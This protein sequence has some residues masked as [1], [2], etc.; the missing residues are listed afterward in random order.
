M[1]P[2]SLFSSFNPRIPA[3]CDSIHAVT[4]NPSIEFQST[5]PC[6][7][8][9]GCVVYGQPGLGVS[10]HA[11]LRDATQQEAAQSRSQSRFNP[12]IPAG[13]DYPPTWKTV[14]QSS[15]NPRIPAGCDYL[16]R[17]APGG[18]QGFNPRIPAGCDSPYV[19]VSSGKD[20]FQSTHPYSFQQLPKYVSI[21]ASLRDAT[22]TIAR[23]IMPSRFQSTHPCGM[24]R[25]I[26]AMHSFSYRFQSTHPCGMRL[27]E[28]G[29]DMIVDV[30]Q[31]THPCG[32]RLRHQILTYEKECFNPRIPAGC[33][34]DQQYG[35]MLGQGFNP[36]IPAGCDNF[37]GQL[38]TWTA[39]SI[40]ASLRDAT[41]PMIL[42]L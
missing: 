41:L 34:G 33:D 40:H 15:F 39:V 1:P 14:K 31:S 29:D 8:R 22:F 13:C 38:N 26:S 27:I 5:H 12:R 16:L 6:G 37:L 42:I 7:M 21:H 3:G 2:S 17:L 4:A 19:V 35:V 18:F 25:Q 11:S 24:R 9:L 30:F 10:I 32:M 28:T 23:W 20:K 36:R